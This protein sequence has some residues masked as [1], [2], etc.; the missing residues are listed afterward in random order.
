M[1]ILRNLVIVG[2]K[3]CNFRFPDGVIGDNQVGRFWSLPEPPSA[4]R[5]TLEPFEGS[6]RPGLPTAW[7]DPFPVVRPS[8]QATPSVRVEPPDCAPPAKLVVADHIG[9][10]V[11]VSLGYHRSN[12]RLRGAGGQAGLVRVTFLTSRA[13]HSKKRNYHG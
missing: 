5:D 2:A 11:A 9:C 12:A 8:R 7:V 3:P 6:A 10:P 1:M 4:G 13:L